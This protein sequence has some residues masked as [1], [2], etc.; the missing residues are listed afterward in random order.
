MK[1]NHE[2]IQHQYCRYCAFCFEA[3]EFR[4]SN[5]PKGKRLYMSREQINRENHCPNFALSDL[6]DVE[7]GKQYRPTQ[8]RAVQKSAIQDEQPYSQQSLFIGE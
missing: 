1:S 3:D 2:H 5:H 7:T 8:K 6:G 4:C